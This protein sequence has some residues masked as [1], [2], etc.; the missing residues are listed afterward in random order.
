MLFEYNAKD[1]Q[2]DEK[3]GTIDSLNMETAMNTLRMRGVG[4]ISIA[5]IAEQK[6]VFAQHITMFDRVSMKEL[7]I[8]SQQISTLA[9]A[10]VSALRIFQ[11]LAMQIQNKYFAGILENVAK[12]LQSGSSISR[13]LAHFP[14]VF[15][16]FY[17]N[18][19]KAGEES[20][21]LSNSFSYLAEYLDRNYEIV[22]K[23]RGALIYPIF[24]IS[25]FF[26]VMA[27]MLTLV[28]PKITE[29]LL[30]A[31]G[32]L[33]IYTK[34]VIWISDFMRNYF[35]LIGVVLIAGGFFFWRWSE[36]ETGKR[37]VDEAKLSIPI[38]GNLYHKLYLTRICDNLSTML[39]S[40]LT[41]LQ[42]LEIT[43]E[44][45]ENV[46]YREALEHVIID[47]RAGKSLS[48][49]MSS[50]EILPPILVQMTKVGEETGALGDILVTLSAFYRREVQ[51]AVAAVIS[52]IEPAMIVLLG[53]GVGVL[54]ASVLLPIYNLTGAF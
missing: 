33:P 11:L 24:V 53:L 44:I 3:N 37:A 45:L 43:A 40:G 8:T 10:Q 28:I 19:V 2:G 14:R 5:P 26:L 12:D 39:T 1:A 31:G 32:E 48:D 25:T 49:S 15:S 47:V 21:T 17:V 42:S 46:V 23:V 6:G 13:A 18:I 52:L 9:N 29:I 38:I 35:G 34:I 41:M 36:T 30:E 50:Q 54:I 7:V 4:V 27:L 20:G 51:T 22:S 16:P